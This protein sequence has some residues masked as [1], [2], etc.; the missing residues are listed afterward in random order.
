MPT[1]SFFVKG[2]WNMIK[3]LKKIFPVL[4]IVPFIIGSVGYHMAG[5]RW[6][7]ACYNSVSLYVIQQNADST[8]ALTEIARWSAALVAT[9][10]ILSILKQAGQYLLN[11][12]L[13]LSSGSAALYGE[14][15]IVNQ[16]CAKE[17]KAFFGGASVVNAKH[18][19]L[20]FH[21]DAENLSFYRK[22]REKMNAGQVWLAVRS[23]DLS[24][25]KAD[26]MNLHFFN[27]NN[28]V[29]KLLW[30]D[31]DIN[32]R[33]KENKKAKIAILG[34][35]SLGE[36]VM[37]QGFLHNVFFENQ[38][39]E[40]HVFAGKEINDFTKNRFVSMN[41][42]KVIFHEGSISDDNETLPDFDLILSTEEIDFNLMEL[43]WI[44]F[45]KALI[46]MY[47]ESNLELSDFMVDDRVRFFGEAE[48]IYT[49]SN[50]ITDK[51]YEN[52]IVLN[53]NYDHYDAPMPSYEVLKAHPKAFKEAKNSW[54]NL[55]EFTKGSNIASAD[56]L[57]IV[58]DLY[59][60]SPY[61]EMQK[62]DRDWAFARLEHIL[63]CRYHF[64]NYWTYGVLKDGKNKDAVKRIHTCLLAFEEL[65]EENKRKDL[66]VILSGRRWGM[67][68]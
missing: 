20:L 44:R 62:E 57:M 10:A 39:Y 41:K 23:L 58:N 30:N 15:E 48:K 42:D 38:E 51:L 27:P 65:S 28:L 24:F 12:I 26:N 33:L 22:H 60:E 59:D 54:S 6:M 47:S 3:K 45:Q 17:K 56:Y 18:Q 2:E 19:I 37:M 52:G 25:L 63:W 36:Q 14:E 43:L 68:K 31:E 49:L 61:K 40:Y 35:E 50:I 21:D 13:C 53:Y 7:D 67:T 4:A 1:V 9:A 16:I 32:T 29:A 66:D 5:L 64:M 46:Y 34:F 55:N 8:N 11:S